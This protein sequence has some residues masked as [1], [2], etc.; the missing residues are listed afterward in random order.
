[1]QHRK[2]AQH[3]IEGLFFGYPTFV[4]V[5]GGG[6]VENLLIYRI[7]ESQAAT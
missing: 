6:V 7:W 3:L 4:A 5:G 1:M 2:F